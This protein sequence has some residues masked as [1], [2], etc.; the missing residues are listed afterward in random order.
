MASEQS[1]PPLK[2][3]P[4]KPNGFDPAA[5]RLLTIV[6]RTGHKLDPPISSHLFP[7]FH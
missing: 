3:H 1:K 6:G 5:G 7:C 2:P 4:R